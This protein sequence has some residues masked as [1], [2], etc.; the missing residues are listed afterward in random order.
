MN[1]FKD[2]FSSL[3]QSLSDIIEGR[4]RK[5]YGADGKTFRLVHER[6]IPVEAS[7]SCASTTYKEARKVVQK[8]LNEVDKASGVRVVAEIKE[9]RSTSKRSKKA[10]E[11]SKML[12][13]VMPELSRDQG[14]E[15]ATAIANK[16]RERVKAIFDTIGSNISKSL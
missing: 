7:L 11:R 3:R 12:K 13:L 5:V 14:D 15:L 6:D 2:I 8:L 1:E 9:I 16:D 10:N 4:F